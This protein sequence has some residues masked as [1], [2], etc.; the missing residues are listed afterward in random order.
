[1]PANI[2]I[3]KKYLNNTFIETG[4]YIG[5]GIQQALNAGF[6]KVISIEL[7]DKYYKICK[8]RFSNNPNVQIIQGDSYKIMP[9]VLKN[10]N[11]SV[12][13]WLDGHHS[14]GDTA[15]GDYWTPLMQEL[16]VIKNHSTN[17]HTILIDDMRCWKQFNPVVGFC[18]KDILVKLLQINSSYKFAYED[19]F[20]KDD[21]LVSY[22]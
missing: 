5:D 9:D 16:D 12:T 4:S 20:E 7:S 6:N 15:L 14:C 13:F 2:K 17:N 8:N 18:E 11:E 21:I 22:I 3:F 19:G 1:M 10:I